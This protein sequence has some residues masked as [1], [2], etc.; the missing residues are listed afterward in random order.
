MEAVALTLDLL[1]KV[2]RLLAHPTSLA[3]SPVWHSG[4]EHKNKNEAWR[5]KQT[6]QGREAS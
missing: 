3:T 2:H 6:P 4:K 1:G 5:G